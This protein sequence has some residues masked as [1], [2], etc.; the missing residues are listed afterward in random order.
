MLIGIQADPYTRESE[1]RKHTSANILFNSI[2]AIVFPRHLYLPYPK[3]SS[4]VLHLLPLL[5]TSLD[6]ATSPA[7]HVRIFPI[8]CPAVMQGTI[9]IPDVRS[10]GNELSV[11]G[12]SFRRD[13]LVD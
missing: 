10:T 5:A 13:D 6:P 9:R 4:T 11:L 3:T 12:I 8:E 7:E 1:M 2:A